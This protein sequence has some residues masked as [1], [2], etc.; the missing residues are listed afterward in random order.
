MC[1]YA[2]RDVDIG[3]WCGL[4]S[5]CPGRMAAKGIAVLLSEASRFISLPSAVRER[6]WLLTALGSRCDTHELRGQRVG[7]IVV[8]E[9]GRK[10][11]RDF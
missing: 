2:L 5:L 11:T 7:A 1:V 6:D 8:L 3:L 9:E 10:V 4:T